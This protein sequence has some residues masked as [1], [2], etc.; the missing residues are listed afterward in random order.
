[1][2]LENHNEWQRQLLKQLS[3]QVPYSL[4][5]KQ[6][7]GHWLSGAQQIL[8]KPGQRIIRPD[9]LPKSL[10]LILKGEIRLIG[11]GDENEGAFTISK[12]GPGQLIGWLGLLR[13]EATEY[14]IASTEVISIALSGVDF[15]KY[16]QENNEF[17]SHFGTLSNIQE[18]YSIA[19]SAAELQPK[20]PAEWRMDINERIKNAKVHSLLPS[21]PLSKL[22]ELPNDWSWFLS[23]TNVPGVPVGTPLSREESYLPEANGFR[24]KYRF[25]GL[26]NGKIKQKITSTQ[27]S[28]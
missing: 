18:S 17:A 1:M 5:E 8:F 20:R 13:A 19:I 22:P 21:E 28:L 27:L 7:L 15:I 4:L 11:V 12:R 10:F 14:V 6:D 16:I 24:L 9:E 2:T 3:N 25:V 26:Q 23:S